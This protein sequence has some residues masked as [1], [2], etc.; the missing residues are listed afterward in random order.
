MSDSTL[1]IKKLL[2]VLFLFV[3]TVSVSFGQTKTDKINSIRSSFQKINTDT[4]LEKFDLDGEDFLE[5]PPDGGASLTGYFKNH[6]LV[7]ISEWIGLSY[8]I[9]QLDYYFENQKPIFIYIVEKQFKYND[10]TGSFDYAKTEAKFEGRYYFDNE[11][12]F[13]KKTKGT[14]IFGTVDEIELGLTTDAKKYSHI[15]SKR[16]NR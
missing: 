14:P 11:K 16:K 10:S 9:K 6:V 1:A 7:K 3:I 13:D 2:G 4:G 5:E 12:L 15:L 8:G